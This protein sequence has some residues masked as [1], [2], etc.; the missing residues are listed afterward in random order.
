MM[1][2]GPTAEQ[3]RDYERKHIAKMEDVYLETDVLERVKSDPAYAEKVRLMEAFLESREPGG[4]T[5]DI[6][7]NT[8]GED[9]VLAH[10]GHHIVASDINEVALALSLRRASKFR[11]RRP[12]YVAADIHRLPFA[13]A[14]FDNATAFEVLHHFENL[15]PALGEIFRVL[16]PGGRLFTYEPSAINPYRRLAEL[17]FLFLGSIERSFTR[18]ALLRQ[19]EAAGFR[20]ISCH[21]HVL[22]PSRWKMKLVSPFRRFLK[23]FYHA[24]AGRCV[25]VFGSL[26]IVAE[27]PGEREAATGRQTLDECLRC[28]VTGQP[29]EREGEWFRTA[30]DSRRYPVKEGIP[31]LI[32]ADAETAE[33]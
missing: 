3:E 30:D 2:L 26:V 28:P 32:A 20:I 10:R 19:L 29:L 31:V 18:R 14:S 33:A 4:R 6:G 21:K 23:K 9:E 17:R 25:P 16:R 7:A 24:V 1:K 5:L 8:A 11:D 15:K 22:P 13:E 27:K 12:E